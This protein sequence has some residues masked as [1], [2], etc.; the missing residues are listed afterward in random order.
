MS[1]SW[2]CSGCAGSYDDSSQAFDVGTRDADLSEP[3]NQQLIM[4]FAAGNSGPSSATVGTPGN[5]KNIIT[6][7]ASENQRPSDEDG[8]WT[9]GCAVGPTGADDAMDVIGFSSRGPSPGGRVKPEVIAPGTHIHGTASTSPNYDGSGVCDQFRPGSQTVIAASSG[10]SHST[11]AVAGV[12][13]LAY[14]WL[15]NPPGSMI[16]DVTVPSPAVMKAYLVAHPTYLTGVSAN[17]TLPSNSQGY[18]MPNMGL[19]FDDTPKAV[20]DQ[21]TVFD[22]TGENFQWFGSAA[23]PSKPVRIV[24]TYTDQAGAVGTSPQVNDLN[25]SVETGG[26]TYLGNNF[27]GQFSVTGGSADA[28]NNYEAVFLPAGTATD[29]TITISAANIAG[30]GIPNVGD[31]TDQ[32]FALVCYNCAQDPTY[33]MGVTD[34]AVSVCSPDDATWDIN[35]GSILGYNTPVTLSTIGLPA[36]A[37]D[38]YSV[39]PVAPGNSSVLTLSNLGAVTA[40]NYAMSVNGA[41]GGDNKTT[42]INLSLFDGVPGATGLSVPADTATGVPGNQVN[43]DW[44]D[45]A[46]ANEYLFELSDMSDFSN[47]IESQTVSDSAYTSALNLNPNSTYYWRVQASNTCGQGALSS[48]FSFTTANEICITPNTAIPDNNPAGVDVDLSLSDTNLVTNVLVKL[49]VEHTWVG[50]L[51]ATM[52]HVN[53]GTT[54]TLM[55]RPGVPA[56]TVGCSADD[57]DVTF[58]DS[59]GTEPVEGVCGSSPAIGGVL[60]PEEPL[61]GFDGLVAD[62]IWRLN[63]S[64]N[65][66]QDTGSITE[67]CIIPSTATDLIFY[68]GFNN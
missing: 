28:A 20:V 43:F 4:L 2:G 67:V 37:T 19:M 66:G 30:D 62:G 63:V 42:N 3:G 31:G 38:G 22:N 51:I 21:S 7:G 35:V 65:I 1:N 58:D 27:S 16:T 68:H 41:S 54:V 45:N 56:S 23:D 12:S 29:L 18:G 52:T 11:P 13:S 25:L 10:T 48:E 61:S 49:Q 36:G 55:D 50:D 24:M 26:N 40:G 44:A 17:D 46:G 47:I 15:Q 6:V 9:D 64:D 8:N 33:T 39:N 59:N 53:S 5:G 14:Y 34:A 32:D 60:L 57:I